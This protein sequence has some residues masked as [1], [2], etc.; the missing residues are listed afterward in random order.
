MACYSTVGYGGSAGNEIYMQVPS[1]EMKE[2]FYGTG[3]AKIAEVVDDYDHEATHARYLSVCNF[4]CW[5]MMTPW[6]LMALKFMHVPKCSEG[7]A[8][9]T[10]EF[11]KHSQ[12]LMPGFVTKVACP[13]VCFCGG[14]KEVQRTLKHNVYL[15]NWHAYSSTSYYKSKM[16][17]YITEQGT[18]FSF[19]YMYEVLFSRVMIYLLDPS[20]IETSEVDDY[21]PSPD[22][23]DGKW[24]RDRTDGHLSLSPPIQCK[25]ADA[26]IIL[27]QKCKALQLLKAAL[28]WH[29]IP[30]KLAE[31][32]MGMA[33]CILNLEDGKVD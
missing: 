29:L 25:I 10:T 12:S 1:Q 4:N 9:W 8:K 16:K 21:F 7:H 31:A 23:A 24:L 30:L 13:D 33:T 3:G 11:I 5:V 15:R 17:A 6:N 14:H 27:G 18:H 2:L 28:A 19:H 20:Q 22:R 32:Q 26:E